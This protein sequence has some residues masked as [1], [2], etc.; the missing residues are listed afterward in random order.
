M[1]RF[2]SLFLSFFR[3]SSVSSLFA[4][5]S[6]K[7]ASSHFHLL[8][9]RDRERLK[10]GTETKIETETKTEKKIKTSK[11]LSRVNESDKEGESITINIERDADDSD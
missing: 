6:E 5:R 9:G 10:K 4:R 7:E 8:G 11:M 2:L 3:I 1:R